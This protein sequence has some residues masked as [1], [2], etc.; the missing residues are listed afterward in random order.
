MKVLAGAFEF[1]FTTITTDLRKD[2]M[3]VR[4]ATA[5]SQKITTRYADHALAFE[6]IQRTKP[7]LKLTG[8]Y[9]EKNKDKTRAERLMED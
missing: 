1:K 5:D 4:K 8:S 7:N 9:P 6:T 2:C 3:A